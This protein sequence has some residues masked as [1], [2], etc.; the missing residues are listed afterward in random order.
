MLKPRSLCFDGSVPEFLAYHDPSPSAVH[1]SDTD[2][3]KLGS[4][5]IFPVARRIHQTCVRDLQC[6]GEGEIFT[7]R[8]KLHAGILHSIERIRNAP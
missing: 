5:Y 7:G 4:E 2:P 8:T 3:A 1:Y 6:R